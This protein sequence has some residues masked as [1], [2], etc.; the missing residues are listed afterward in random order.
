MKT[1]LFLSLLFFMNT[2]SAFSQPATDDLLRSILNENT[3]PVFQQVLKDPQ[4]YRLQIIYTRIDR[5]KNN[6]PTFTNYYF[7][8][9]PQ[10]YFNPASMVKLPLAALALEKL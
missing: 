9:D 2:E 1:I 6:K 7:N 10:L 5:D 4:S 3:D 8:H